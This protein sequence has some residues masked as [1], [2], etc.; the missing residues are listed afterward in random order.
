MFSFQKRIS[1]FSFALIPLIITTSSVSAESISQHS[2]KSTH[3]IAQSFSGWVASLWQRRPKRQN[4]ARFVSDVCVVSPGII[5]TYMVWSDR[6]LF[7]WYYSGTARETQLIV[8]EEESQ[9]IVL[10]QPV[11]LADQQFLYNGTK[12]LEP[13]KTYQWQLS[14]STKWTQFHTM[15]ASEHGKIQADLQALEQRLKASKASSEEIVLRKAAYFLNYKVRNS[16]FNPW[17][18]ALEALYEVAKPSQ[19][20]VDK[21]QAFVKSMCPS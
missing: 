8:R 20:F 11:N 4:F 6:P 2:P 12:P 1:L 3:L 16:S 17:S 14:G 19:S 18:D 7:L 9:K 5:D 10:M 13:D 21:R 15:S